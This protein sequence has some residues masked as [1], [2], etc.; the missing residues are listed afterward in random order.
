VCSACETR[1]RRRE[2]RATTPSH[3]PSH[4]ARPGARSVQ[5]RARS[6][7]ARAASA[8]RRAGAADSRRLAGRGRR[9]RD[10]DAVSAVRGHATDDGACGGDSRRRSAARRAPRLYRL[11][12]AARGMVPARGC[13]RALVGQSASASGRDATLIARKIP[14]PSRPDCAARTHVDGTNVARPRRRHA[15]GIGPREPRT[16][17]VNHPDVLGLAL[18]ALFGGAKRAQGFHRQ[19]PP[20][21]A[22]TGSG[23]NSRTS[24]SPA[25]RC[26]SPAASRPGCSPATRTGCC[27]SST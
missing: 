24:S 1:L 23:D 19:T 22:I 27:I 21:V 5:P 9:H 12:G 3:G 18:L 25:R 15:T 8:G 14:R 10:R 20:I 17:F 6:R 26:T 4:A 7:T 11:P 16:G 13:R 2:P